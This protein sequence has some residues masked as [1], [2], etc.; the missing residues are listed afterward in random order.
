M[1]T[2]ENNIYVIVEYANREW[3]AYNHVVHARVYKKLLQQLAELEKQNE[4]LM[5]E[6]CRRST[7]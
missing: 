4:E 5:I 3:G 6:L 2:D 1:I 7:K